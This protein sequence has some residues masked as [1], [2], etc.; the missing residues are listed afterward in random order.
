MVKFLLCFSMLLMSGS[1]FAQYYNYDWTY[2]KDLINLFIGKQKNFLVKNIEPT[3]NRGLKYRAYIEYIARKQDVPREV[4][5][6]ASIESGFNKKAESHAGAVG[7][8]QLMKPTANDMGLTITSRIDERQNWKKSTV[9]AIKYIKQLSN[10]FDGDYE[11]ALLAYN[12]GIGNV[13]KSIKRM[14]SKNAWFLV[15]N[16]PNLKKES[17]EYLVKFIIYAYYFEH[18][19]NKL[20]LAIKNNK[21]KLD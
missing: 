4:F 7:M 17:K 1:S 19:D 9:A 3:Y 12:A 20:K 21:K 11:L 6:I 15:K 5:A 2:D 18:L 14:N 10:E 16:D 13:R 8:W